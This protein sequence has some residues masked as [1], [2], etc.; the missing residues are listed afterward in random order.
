MIGCGAGTTGCGM[1]TTGSGV[2]G[3]TG[4]VV[5]R[6]CEVADVSVEFSGMAGR[7]EEEAAVRGGWAGEGVSREPSGMA[8]REEEGEEVLVD[9]AEADKSGGWMPL[10]TS[11][12]ICR[13]CSFSN[14]TI[15]FWTWVSSCLFC[16]KRCST[17]A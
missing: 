14:S 11:C 4:S 6:D 5:G 3:I 8:G 7:E 16:C 2:G 1:G 10:A 12:A 17:R 13:D 9:L 15:S